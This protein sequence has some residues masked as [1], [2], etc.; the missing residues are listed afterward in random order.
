MG[1]DFV[2]QVW[3][4]RAGGTQALFCVGGGRKSGREVGEGCPKPEM[5]G[6]GLLD[7]HLCADF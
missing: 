7:W 5:G 6:G 2:H 1:E 3:A 4:E